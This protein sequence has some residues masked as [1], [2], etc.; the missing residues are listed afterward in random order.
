MQDG[1]DHEHDVPLQVGESVWPGRGVPAGPTLLPSTHQD[2]GQPK[3]LP[4]SSKGVGHPAHPGESPSATLLSPPLACDLI[5]MNKSPLVHLHGDQGSGKQ[6]CPGTRAA[7]AVVSS[8]TRALRLHEVSTHT[9]G[10]ACLLPCWELPRPTRP[11]EGEARPRLFWGVPV[12]PTSGTSYLLVRAQN[13]HVLPALVSHLR[14]IPQKWGLLHHC[15]ARAFV[16]WL[17]SLRSP[18]EAQRAQGQPSFPCGF[19]QQAPSRATH[20]AD[21]ALCGC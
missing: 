10:A 6:T 1:L 14:R 11:G 9:W 18:G 12:A 19:S 13:S 5:N 8:E 21:S 7:P 15:W 4:E 20:P 16:S 17:W 3:L 2:G